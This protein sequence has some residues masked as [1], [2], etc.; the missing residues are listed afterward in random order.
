MDGLAYWKGYLAK[1]EKYLTWRFCSCWSSCMCHWRSRW[2]S[3]CGCYG[4]SGCSNSC[5]TWSGVGANIV[6]EFMTPENLPIRFPIIIRAG[7][8]ESHGIGIFRIAFCSTPHFAV[9][10]PFTRTDWKEI[11]C[12]FF[13]T[14]GVADILPVVCFTR[15]CSRGVETDDCCLSS[16]FAIASDG[17]KSFAFVSFWEWNLPHWNVDCCSGFETKVGIALHV[18]GNIADLDR[19]VGAAL[20]FYE[21]SAGPVASVCWVV[22]FRLAEDVCDVLTECWTI[23]AS[24]L[25]YE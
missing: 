21:A 8:L 5:R 22:A 19:W 1:E 10:I 17:E 13:F 23:P 12:F 6:L 20:D 4:C 2:C 18:V 25:M 3:C 11:C 9:A 14:N 7:N 15:Q 24:A 16:S